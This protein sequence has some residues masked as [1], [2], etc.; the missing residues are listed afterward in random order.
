[1]SETSRSDQPKRQG[2]R[3]PAVRAEEN[4]LFL[5]HLAR[6]GNAKTSAAACGVPQET[7][8]RRRKKDGDFAARWDAALQT[9]AKALAHESEVRLLPEGAPG[10]L[11]TDGGEA[12][13]R[14]GVGGRLQLRRSLPGKLTQTACDTFLAHLAATSNVTMA[15]E[16]TGFDSSPFYALAARDESFAGAWKQA[17]AAGYDR[18]EMGLVECA[19]RSFDPERIEA[20]DDQ[21]VGGTMSAYDALQLL[22]LHRRTQRL[23]WDRRD[24]QHEAVSWE[25]VEAWF[26]KELARP[27]WRR[28]IEKARQAMEP[29]GPSRDED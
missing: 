1:M 2:P 24:V 14:R 11:K 22:T 13:V 20:P 6:T 4:R 12:V 19:N 5:R 27:K 16:A 17:M 15:A 23:G 18:L 7:M 28:A 9:A 29:A 21:A 26:T 3:K 8:H 10:D 25:D